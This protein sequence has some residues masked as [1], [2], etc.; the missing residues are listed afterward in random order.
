[1]NRCILA[2]AALAF[3]SESAARADVRPQ[4]QPPPAPG[5]IM[6]ARDAKLI[7]QKDDNAKAARLVIPAGLLTA[8]PGPRRIGALDGL[9]AA[10]AGLALTAAFVSGG[11]WLVRKKRTLAAMSLFA[12]LVVFG[13]TAVQADLRPVPRPPAPVTV[14]F[15]ATV[16]HDGKLTLEIVPAG[17]TIQLIMPTK[18]I[19]EAAPQPK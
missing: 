1:M 10:V 11:F 12:S 6:G 4:P 7:V 9:P 17:D 18:A 16:T 13:T 5:L 2:L 8:Q 15:P 19:A 14:N 3:L